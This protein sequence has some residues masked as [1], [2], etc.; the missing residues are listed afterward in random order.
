MEVAGRIDDVKQGR[1]RL[2]R[3]VKTAPRGSGISRDEITGLLQRTGDLAQ[4]AVNAKPEGATHPVSPH[5]ITAVDV[6]STHTG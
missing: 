5:P 1:A 6:L 2:E 3:E 4:L